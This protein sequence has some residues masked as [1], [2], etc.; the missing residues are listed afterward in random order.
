MRRDGAPAVGEVV[1]HRGK[2]QRGEAGRRAH[3]HVIGDFYVPMAITSSNFGMKPLPDEYV[4]KIAY[5]QHFNLSRI[6][7]NQPVNPEEFQLI[8]PEGALVWDSTLE[9]PKAAGSANTIGIFD[10]AG[11]Q[12]IVNY[13]QP[14]NPADV[15]KAIKEAKAKMGIAVTAPNPSPISPR[16]RNVMW[17]IIAANLALF[18]VIG[19]FYA[20]R[21]WS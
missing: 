9:P 8:P 20:R 7:V 15:P 21:R 5:K 18:A 4:G 6:E 2:L 19:A 13:I 3:Q 14:E 10:D 11:A 1:G 12:Q 17:W 16:T